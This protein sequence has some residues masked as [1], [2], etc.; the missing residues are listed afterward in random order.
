MVYH[1]KLPIVMPKHFE[2]NL[3][4]NMVEGESFKL[5]SDFH[6]LMTA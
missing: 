5:S 3:S 4:D 1:V 6:T 2:F